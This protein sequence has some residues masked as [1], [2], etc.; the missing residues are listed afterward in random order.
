MSRE[1]SRRLSRTVDNPGIGALLRHAWQ[2]IRERIYL[3]VHQDGYTDLNRAHVSLFRYEGLEGRRPGQLAD[4]MQITKQSVNDLLRYMEKCGY[5]KCIPDGTDKRARLV[6]L[7]LR[8]RR[9]DAV[10]RNHAAAAEREL[11][12]A[13][14][15]HAFRDLYDV[16]LKISAL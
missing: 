10:V 11:A 12:Q 16:L 2:R 9:L 8:G 15:K 4:S 6:H 1:Y 5:V 13:V 7:T 3:G 14:G